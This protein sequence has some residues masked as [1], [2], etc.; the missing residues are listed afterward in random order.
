MGPDIHLSVMNL[1]PHASRR[2]DGGAVAADI[3]QVSFGDRRFRPLMFLQIR[4]LPL[5]L[6]PRLGPAFAPRSASA[7]AANLRGRWTHRRTCKERFSGH[8][9]HGRP[10]YKVSRACR[11]SRILHSSDQSY[12]GFPTATSRKITS[13]PFPSRSLPSQGL[14][15]LLPPQVVG[16]DSFPEAP[17]IVEFLPCHEGPWF[18]AGLCSR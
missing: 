6:Q 8:T 16:W 2:P 13:R 15:R 14:S 17:F 18:G 9:P 1:R 11:R 5:Y 4:P 10:S 3:H 7:F 12:H